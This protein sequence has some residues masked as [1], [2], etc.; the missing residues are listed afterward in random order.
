MPSAPGNKKGSISSKLPFSPAPSSLWVGE[1]P[2]VKSGS[3]GDSQPEDTGTA[4]D[5]G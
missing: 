1:G 2:I 3:T 4:T 5:K